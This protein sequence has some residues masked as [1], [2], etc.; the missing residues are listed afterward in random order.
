MSLL[1]ERRRYRP[2]LDV[3]VS[4]SMRCKRLAIRDALRLRQRVLA[5]AAQIFA[6]HRAGELHARAALLVR[7]I[8]QRA[9]RGDRDA[10]DHEQ[11]DRDVDQRDPYAERGT[12]GVELQPVDECLDAREHA[13]KLSGRDVGLKPT[14]FLLYPVRHSTSVLM[15]S[16]TTASSVRSEATANAPT[17]LYSW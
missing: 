3:R 12:R 6:R 11:H 5:V 15:T 14:Y 10:A 7:E 16:V 9:D 1:Q 2:R 8:A 17:K 4:A 13:V